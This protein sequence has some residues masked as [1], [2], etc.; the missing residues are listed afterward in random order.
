MTTGTTKVIYWAGLIVLI[1]WLVRGAVVL[2]PKYGV[3]GFIG[4]T[5]ADLRVW[6]LVIGVF[7]LYRRMRKERGPSATERHSK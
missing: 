7:L 4:G 5:V 1:F 2:I 3:F 6:L